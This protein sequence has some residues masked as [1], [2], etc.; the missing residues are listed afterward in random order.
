MN[1]S[2]SNNVLLVTGPEDFTDKTFI[3]DKLVDIICDIH[4]IKIIT[5][6]AIGVDTIVAELC[7]QSNTP[8]ERYYANRDK[9]GTSASSRRNWDMTLAATHVLAFYNGSQETTDVLYFAN[10]HNLIITKII[11]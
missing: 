5:G 9:Y 1:K 2:I 4:P 10:R 6:D 11:I 3:C 8:Y 7:Y